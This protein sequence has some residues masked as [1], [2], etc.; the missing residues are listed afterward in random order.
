M[1]KNEWFETTFKGDYKNLLIAADEPKNRDGQKLKTGLFIGFENAW[2][3]ASVL[4]PERSK[5]D[6]E[7][8]AATGVVR[9]D[10]ALGV[11]QFGPAA[12]M[13]N[14]LVKGNLLTFSDK[15]ATIRAEGSFNIGENIK[16]LGIKVAGI[17][18]TGLE[19]SQLSDPV[20]AHTDLNADFVA[21]F[22]FN[23]PKNLMKIMLTDFASGSFDAQPVVYDKTTLYRTAIAEWSKDDK[24]RTNAWTTLTTKHLFDPGSDTPA[25]FVLGEMQ[26]T[27]NSNLQSFVTSSEKVALNSMGR[28][29]IHRYVKA[30]VEF[31]MPSNKD[32]RLYLILTADSGHY[33][34]FNYKKGILHVCSNNED[35]NKEVAE[36]SDNARRIEVVKG[37]PYELQLTTPDI[38]QAFLRRHTD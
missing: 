5:R 28:Q 13:A 6:R 22:D 29:G 38:V 7:L 10:N 16:E 27:W 26:M 12:R 20:L 3:Y 34:Y 30:L 33:Y 15:N 24:A 19:A 31:R 18:H 37:H 23:L 11:C 8:F 1:S 36:M 32:D 9:Y 14:P 17:A 25:T 2:N 35:F 21:G 4:M